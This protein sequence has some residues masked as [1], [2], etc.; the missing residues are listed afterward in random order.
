MNTRRSI[1]ALF[2]LP[3]V[4]LAAGCGGGDADKTEEAVSE[5]SAASGNVLL[6]PRDPVWAAHAPET[7]RARFETSK[8]DFVIEVQRAWAPEGAD[9]FFNLVRNGFYDDVRF[10]RVID[11]FMAQFGIHGDPR[12]AAVWRGRPIPD[13]SVVRS[14]TRGMVSFAMAGPNTRT[15]QV[16]INYVDNARLDEMGFPPFG[17]VVEGMEVVDG[18]YAEYGEGAPRGQGPA[19]QY[20]QSQGNAYLDQEFPELD[21]VIRATIIRP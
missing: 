13:D 4:L 7:Y 12:V 5:E 21:R 2:S 20:I 11:G 8:G 10:F 19:Q 9:R 14:N 16:F 17:R 6:D 3:L 18:L 15:T 1:S